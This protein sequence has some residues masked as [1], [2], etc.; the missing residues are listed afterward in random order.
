MLQPLL[1]EVEQ[2]EHREYVIDTPHLRVRE[3]RGDAKALKAW[4][5]ARVDEGLFTLGP[6]GFDP[7]TIKPYILELSP[8]ASRNLS[9]R[10][11]A[12]AAALGAATTAIAKDPNRFRVHGILPSPLDASAHPNEAQAQALMNSPLP[13]GVNTI[14]FGRL[15]MFPVIDENGDVGFRAI[16]ANMRC[17]EG[18][19][20]VSVVQGSVSDFDLDPSNKTVM[21]IPAE[22]ML[23]VARE[24]YRHLPDEQKTG[25]QEPRVGFVYWPDDKVKGVET[26]LIKHILDRDKTTRVSTGRPDNLGI[27]VAS[28]GLKDVYLV[29]D[30]G[31]DPVKLDVVYRN[32]GPHDFTWDTEGGV[33]QADL[34][35]EIIKSPD[36]YNCVVVPSARQAYAG[37]KSLFAM[38]SDPR[39]EEVFT[40]AMSAEVLAL[41]RETVG[42]SRM[43]SEQPTDGAEYQMVIDNPCRFAIK[44]IAGSGGADVVL[45]WSEDSIRKGIE[46]FPEL[47][48]IMEPGEDLG[49]MWRHVVEA[50]R[51]SG[52]YLV[53]EKIKFVELEGGL[54]MD[55]NP[56]IVNGKFTGEILSRIG[57]RQPINV[58]QG[59]GMMPVV[60][61]VTL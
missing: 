21:P 17:V 32:I 1:G 2:V 61:G 43:L 26:P 3:L 19:G 41:A 52:G 4:Q 45:G 36:E 42:W 51:D 40:G 6:N 33:S 60:L 58:K 10:A 47:A 30:D 54:V 53:Q 31:K 49:A 23:E 20:Y 24:A 44:H 12:V 18:G 35:A 13:A 7:I 8:E 9:D 27:Q 16:E 22:A 25:S 29:A 14:A 28:N 50:A 34:L 57:D 46:M 59:G 15:D 48:D 39:F 55:I 56:Y 38:I 5:V 11:N 37:Y